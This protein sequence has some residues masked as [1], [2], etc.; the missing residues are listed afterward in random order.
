MEAKGSSFMPGE[1]NVEEEKRVMVSANNSSG[2]SEGTAKT[3]KKRSRASRRA[4]TTV[5]TTDA[6]NFRSMV[7]EFTGIPSP[8]VVPTALDSAFLLKPFPQR[9]PIAA[10]AA[11]ASSSYY[12]GF[13][14]F[15]RN[16]L[17]QDYQRLPNH[18]LP[19]GGIPG[20]FPWNAA[21]ASPDSSSRS[22][23]NSGVDSSAWREAL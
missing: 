17:Q 8:P 4:P 12:S 20:I 6:S 1:G 5:L 13:C 15:A 19:Q 18:L 22:V 10:A 3:G 14:G 9:H 21:F 23:A 11:A 16:P 7:Q 2:R